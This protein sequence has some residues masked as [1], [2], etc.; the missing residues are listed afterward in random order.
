L[1]AYVVAELGLPLKYFTIPDIVT[2]CII[3]GKP[4]YRPCETY[5]DLSIWA[6]FK[7]ILAERS[8]ADRFILLSI[9]MAWI[10]Y[11]PV[12]SHDQWW[13]LWW[14]AIA[15]FLAAGWESFYGFRSNYRIIREHLG[16]IDSFF[17]RVFS[18]VPQL[19]AADCAPHTTGGGDDG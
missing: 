3:F 5:W 4:R 8:P 6:Q 7:C 18:P 19:R 2:V 9:P 14:I 15:Q 13:S 12:L 16:D 1:L 10:I 11:S 17:L